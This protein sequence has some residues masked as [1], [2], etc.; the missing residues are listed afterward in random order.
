MHQPLS[1]II[2]IQIDYHWKDQILLNSYIV[3]HVIFV[4]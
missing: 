4:P 2:E 3:D 1:G